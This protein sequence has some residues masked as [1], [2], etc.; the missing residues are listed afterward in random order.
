MK[1][2][3]SFSA[4]TVWIAGVLIASA[5]LS[6]AETS[7]TVE[8]KPAAGTAPTWEGGLFFSYLT[9]DYG[10]DRRTDIYYGSVMIKRYLSKGD[11]TLT[12]PYLD[13]P[14]NGVTFVGGTAE[15]DT[16][17]SGGSG[18]GD[19]ILKGRYYAVEQDG[20]LPFIDLVGS[21]KFPTADED[22]GLGT[23]EFDFTALSEFTWRLGDS[24]WSAL[25][26]LGYTFVGKI[27][28]V[29]MKNRWL[30]SAGLAY[31][32]DPKLT[33]SG[34]LDGRTAIFEGEENPLSILLMGQYKFRPDL[35]MD[36]LLEFGL[37]DGSPDFGVTLGLRKRI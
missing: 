31:E 32:V 19:I 14:S 13:I 25:A 37:T 6:Y 3:L 28:G 33:L 18:L 21:I 15:A 10:L 24:P 9:G 1:N 30:Y 5:S 12:V 26:E 2:Q 23:G 4:L 34:Y 20:P 16:S 22:K 36:T 7:A 17:A 8:T 27:P 35:R 11:I 29:D